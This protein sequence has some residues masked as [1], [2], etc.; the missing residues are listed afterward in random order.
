MFI[1]INV[2]VLLMEA[3]KEFLFS[4]QRFKVHLIIKFFWVV[5]TVKHDQCKLCA[6]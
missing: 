5:R 6:V 4:D 1:F 3:F 2:L